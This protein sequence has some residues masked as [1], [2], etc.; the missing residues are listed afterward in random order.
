VRCCRGRR[1]G[2]RHAGR[3]LAE[4][5]R[6]HIAGGSVATQGG[7]C[8]YTY[9]L[10]RP[11]PT[12]TNGRYGGCAHLRQPSRRVCGIIEPKKP[13]RLWIIPTSPEPWGQRTIGALWCSVQRERP[14]GVTAEA[15]RRKS[16]ACKTA[17]MLGGSQARTRELLGLAQAWLQ[18]A[19]YT[20]RHPDWQSQFVIEVGSTQPRRRLSNLDPF[21]SG[22]NGFCFETN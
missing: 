10:A 1:R 16:A 18:L 5:Q 12:S 15:F 4:Q 13:S 9:R 6:T 3:P 21:F 2:R 19:E 17:A 20:E 22:Q 14:V 11:P 8:V 7:R